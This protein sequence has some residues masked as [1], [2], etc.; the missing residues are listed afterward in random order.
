MTNG[1]VS[2]SVIKDNNVQY[3]VTI[4]PTTDGANIILEESVPYQYNIA[5][6]AGNDVTFSIE[7][8]GNWYLLSTLK[9]ANGSKY[10]YIENV[11]NNDKIVKVTN[12]EI[13]TYFTA[14][15]L[16]SIQISNPSNNSN[17]SV[18]QSGDTVE[19][20]LV[21][22]GSQQAQ[23]YKDIVKGFDNANN[24]HIVYSDGDVVNKYTLSSESANGFQECRRI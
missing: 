18:Y 3:A 2:G 6:N 5:D 9:K 4:T 20:V 13:P 23:T 14:D 1:L 17:S 21:Y 22:T 16:N 8:S 19:N 12:G 15:Q 24:T 11:S 10:Y 7:Y